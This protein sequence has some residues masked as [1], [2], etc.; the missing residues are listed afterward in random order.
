MDRIAVVIPTVTGRADHLARCV[1]EY[2]KYDVEILVLPNRSCCGDAWNQGAAMVDT[3]YVH[4]TADDLEP[5]PGWLEA[6]KEVADQG[7]IPAP[8]VLRPDGSSESAGGLVALVPF[9]PRELWCHIG[10]V[11]A[12]L[13]YYTDNW[14]TD[15]GRDLGFPTVPCEDYAFVHHWAQPGRGAGMSEPDRLAHDHA[16]YVKELERARA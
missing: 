7:Q 16:V 2:A 1:T 9:L 10:P 15:R 14:I 8:L 5:L 6:A 4:F 12:G 13:H 3:K 11:P